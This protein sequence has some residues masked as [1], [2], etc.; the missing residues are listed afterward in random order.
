MASWYPSLPPLWALGSLSRVAQ[1]GMGRADTRG[2]SLVRGRLPAP[3]Q[4]PF[5]DLSQEL[6]ARLW[7]AGQ[8][9]PGLL[10]GW[11]WGCL[12]LRMHK[13]ASLL[14]AAL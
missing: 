3:L 2:L 14:H 13:R 12:Q 11:D 7:E 5:P 9:P 6:P 4:K 1:C 10:R 8:T